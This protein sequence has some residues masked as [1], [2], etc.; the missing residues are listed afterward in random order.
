MK[1]KQKNSISLAKVSSSP[2]KIL[3]NFKYIIDKTYALKKNC[4]N[5]LK[6]FMNSKLILGIQKTY[7]SSIDLLTS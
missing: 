1:K 7:K 5:L 2:L 6:V 4:D 3:I